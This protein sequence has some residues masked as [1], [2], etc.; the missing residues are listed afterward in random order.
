[1]PTNP[2]LE[3]FEANRNNKDKVK[4]L[5]ATKCGD[6]WAD[7]KLVASPYSPGP[8]HDDEE[9]VRQV[10]S[11]LHWDE[12]RQEVKPGFYDDLSNKGLSLNRLS[13]ATAEELA[14]ASRERAGARGREAMGFV[15]CTAGQMVGVMRSVNGASGA[16]FDTADEQ[17]VSHADACQTKGVSKIEGRAMKQKL[18]EA[19]KS[20]FQAI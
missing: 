3:F 13:Y 8:I 14:Q 19:L 16:I 6:T 4:A 9:I 20:C 2:C 11:P 17:D 18:F 1:M 7:A 5:V 15:R 10:H 12:A